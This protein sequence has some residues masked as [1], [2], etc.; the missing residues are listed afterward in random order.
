MRMWWLLMLPRDLLYGECTRMDYCYGI[1]KN[2]SLYR[3]VSENSAYALCA[4]T[5]NFFVIYYIF[6]YE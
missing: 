5:R 4:D 3:Y 2:L 1:M 6:P